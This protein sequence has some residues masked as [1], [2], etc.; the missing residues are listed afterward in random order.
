MIKD[1]SGFEAVF[2]TD[3]VSKGINCWKIRVNK[4]YTDYDIDGLYHLFIGVFDDTKADMEKMKNSNLSNKRMIGGY[5]Y[6]VTYGH[7]FSDGCG[8]Y[9]H[10]LKPRVS[11]DGDIVDLI[12]DLDNRTLGCKIND[13]DIERSIDGIK[14]GKYRLCVCMYYGDT[15]LELL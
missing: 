6:E 5:I 14:D 10:R 7:T 2:G 3:I 9:T 12:L 4:L 15:E 8:N 13:K 11:K 1:S